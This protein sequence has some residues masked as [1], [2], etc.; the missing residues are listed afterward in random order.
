MTNKT[1][2]KTRMPNYPP[3]GIPVYWRD[4]ITGQLPAAVD[5]YLSHRC[6]GAEPSVAQITFLI[7]YLRHY[8]CAPCW[9]SVARDARES[10]EGELAVLLVSL[11]KDICE[12]RVKTSD[13]IAA[14]IRRA[15]SL[16]LDPL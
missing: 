16:G 2:V 10:G 3:G 9:S 12:G 8:V 1:A 15:L 11:R 4:E 13:E 5:A 7:D 14:W 6:G